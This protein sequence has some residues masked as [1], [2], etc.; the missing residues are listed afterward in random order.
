MLT[1]ITPVIKT[2]R[3]PKSGAHPIY[4]RFSRGGNHAYSRIAGITTR[5]EYWSARRHRVTSRH[6][7][8]EW[9]NTQIE[10]ALGRAREALTLARREARDHSVDDVRGVFEGRRI[11]GGFF[12]F[13]DARLEVMRRAGEDPNRKGSIDTWITQSSTMS[14]F[15]R[16]AGET[17]SW[18]DLT[19][20]LLRSWDEEMIARG[21]RGSTRRR[22]LEQVRSH[23]HAAIAQGRIAR[24]DDPFE[25]FE[26]PKGEATNKR[27]LTKDQIRALAE[28][29]LPEGSDDAFA[30]DAYCLAFLMRGARVRDVLMMRWRD[31]RSARWE[32]VTSK[33]GLPMSAPVL[34]PAQEILARYGPS[35]HPDQFVFPRM[36]GTYR[37]AEALA[38]HARNEAKMIGDRLKRIAEAAGVEHPEEV[39][40]HT[41]R[42]SWANEQKALGKPVAA[43]MN[44]VGHKRLSTTQ[45]YL[46][47]FPTPELD[48]LLDDL[49]SSW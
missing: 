13:A 5:K 34:E 24:A 15:K 17:L 32:Y 26:M 18:A 1:T 10:E 47:P 39:T 35:G 25:G 9:V 27:R 44:G 7:D 3:P 21:N 42:H 19:P 31:V 20:D 8:H 23:F 41:S 30:R 43:I 12:E 48:E 22:K 46:G 28:L 4:I 11:A 6:P 40:F 36:Q 38:R 45:G 14:M 2:A 33:T 37:S 49:T 16:F 29:E